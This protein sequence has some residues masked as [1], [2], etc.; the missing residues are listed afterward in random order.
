[1]LPKLAAREAQLRELLGKKEASVNDADKTKAEKL[2]EKIRADYARA[3]EW[4]A[5]KEALAK[6]VWRTVATHAKRLNAEVARISPAIIEQTERALASTL[7][8]QA[9]LLST[10]SSISGAVLAS[11]KTPSLLAGDGA[12]D[13]AAALAAATAGLAGPGTPGAAAAASH[14]R[15]FGGGRDSPTGMAVA[16]PRMSS[17]D[18]TLGSPGPL[19][20][21]GAGGASMLGAG[22]AA[23]Q[24]GSGANTHPKKSLKHSG[25][26]TVL[27]SKALGED[28]AEGDLEAAAGE[29]KDDR[30]YCHCQRVSFGEMIGCDSDDCIYEWFHLSCVGLSKPLPQTWYCS[31]CRERMEREKAE[32]RPV[33]KRKKIPQ[34]EGSQPV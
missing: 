7:P 4:G 16:R 11:L 31:D 17:S 33:K 15:K 25:L 26:S 29:E 20:G 28:D 24:A 3:D 13:H 30:V 34:K 1:M 6:D 12:T 23:G 22:A 5:Q 10:T 27:A 32:Q 19:A 14:K 2:A 21:A 8:S 18:R 9:Q